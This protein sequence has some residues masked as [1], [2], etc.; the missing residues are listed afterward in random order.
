M[1]SS[2]EAVID[3]TPE[4]CN[5]VDAEGHRCV[6]PA[7]MLAH[8]WHK[9]SLWIPV[10]EAL[11]S[12]RK[13]LNRALEVLSYPP[14][15]TLEDY[16]EFRQFIGSLTCVRIDSFTPCSWADS[17]FSLSDRDCQLMWLAWRAGFRSAPRFSR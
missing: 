6:N 8:G 3:W 15:S 1:S 2:E 10:W 16:V 14:E 5:C 17:P 11:E 4:R 12:S 9:D 7:A 13:D